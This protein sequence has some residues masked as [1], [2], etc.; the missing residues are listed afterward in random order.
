METPHDML[1]PDRDLIKTGNYNPAW[2]HSPFTEE[3]FRDFWHFFKDSYATCGKENRPDPPDPPKV[4]QVAPSGSV[5]SFTNYADV[6]VKLNRAYSDVNDTLDVLVKKWVEDSAKWSDAGQKAINQVIDDKVIPMAPVPP[7][8]GIKIDD[9]HWIWITAACNSANDE[10]EKVA[11]GQGGV[12]GNINDETAKIKDLEKQIKALEA[13]S[14][15]PAATPP[16]VDPTNWPTTG[17]TDQTTP[18][19]IDTGDLP[20]GLDGLDNPGS[21]SL[22]PAGL[23][24]TGLDGTDGTDLNGQTPSSLDPTG[25]STPGVTTPTTPSVPPTAAASPMG[26]GMDMMSSM[27]PMMM[28]Q[29]M[30][31]N[32]ADQD[33]NSRRAELDPDR[34]DDELAQVTPPPVAPPVT[35]QPAVVQPSTTAP[36]AQHSGA[37]PG[38]TSSTQP[39]VAP[40]RTPGAD[41]SVEY[42]FPDGRTQKVSAM[43]AQALDA[44]FGNRS[45]TD[46]QKAYE[47]TSAKWSDKKQIG[48]SVDPFQLMTGDVAV[49]EKRTAILVVFPSDD[50]AGTLEAIV[51]GEL[52]PCNPPEMT[53][54]TGEFGSFSGFVH[55]KGIEVT[56]PADGAVPPSTPG[57]ADQSATAAMPVVAAG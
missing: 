10:L 11:N 45:G 17:S 53:D 7:V 23:D 38:T 55:P 22:T 16:T 49:W 54:K 5:G 28:Q 26:S 32:M 19:T 25:T 44:A 4:A 31:R 8:D 40:G 1:M 6:A 50:G 57:S 27:L 48:T 2:V 43:V 41:G 37:P 39:T 14:K 56:A 15:N 47:K 29:A 51:D 34:F 21:D 18:P 24:G 35:A 46:A 36:A 13:A 52:K 9:H 33:L 12:A 42:T 20:T 3:R 30:M